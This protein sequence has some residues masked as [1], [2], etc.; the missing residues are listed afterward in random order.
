[1]GTLDAGA[2]P[3]A[4][5]AGTRPPVLAGR[6]PQLTEVDRLLLRAA[7]G[8]SD[9]P[10]LAVG[11]RGVGKTVLLLALRDRARADG[12]IAVHAQARR[13]E[14]VVRA[15]LRDLD[16]ELRRIRS[17]RR[18]VERALAAIASVT[19][20][21]GAVTVAAKPR[22]EAGRPDDLAVGLLEVFRAVAQVVASGDRS[23]LLTI[24]ELQEL[25]RGEMS[26]LLVAVQRAT[27]EGLPIVTVV[28][29]LPGAQTSAAAVE[30]F[31]E[32][33]FAVWPLGP[34]SRQAATAALVEPARDAGGVGWDPAAVGV[35]VSASAGYPFYLQHFGARVW[36]VAGNTPISTADA[37]LGIERAEHELAASLVAAQLGRLSARE[38]RYVQALA[39]LGAGTHSSGSVAAEMGVATSQLGS[40]RQRLIRAGI[41]YSP[42]YGQVAFTLPLFDRTVLQALDDHRLR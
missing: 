19:V 28:A 32:R 23:F 15:V 41:V 38:R 42:R 9:Q 27:G 8:Y 4:P 5:G 36:D 14:G 21:V 31:A 20:T 17:G 11:V 3:Y 10:R 34:L 1:M 29:G 7:R 33:M 13:D 12:G 22:A 39:Q 24:D 30:S 16:F 26:A 18:L 35:V 2:N 37:R 40:L 25:P 6:D